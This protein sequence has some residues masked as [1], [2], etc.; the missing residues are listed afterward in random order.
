MDGRPAGHEWRHE[1]GA[2]LSLAFR[3]CEKIFVD[4]PHSA[5]DGPCQGEIIGL[6]DHRAVEAR[7]AQLTLSWLPAWARSHPLRE[8][9][10][11]DKTPVLQAE[12]AAY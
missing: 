9:E 3:G 2:S 4:E 11:L 12:P 1:A 7:D 10:A 6:T 8:F 5:I